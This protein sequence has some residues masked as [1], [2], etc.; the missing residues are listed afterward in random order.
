MS[1]PAEPSSLLAPQASR[2]SDHSSR[3][4]G[5]LLSPG[6]AM[7]NVGLTRFIAQPGLSI[8]LM[9]DEP[10]DYEL[11]AKWLTDE[12]V[13][14]FAYG[15]DKPFGVDRV[16]ARFRPRVRGEDE[17]VPCILG[18]NDIPVGYMQYYPV[19]AGREYGIEAVTGVFGVDLFIGEPD[20]WDRGIGAQALGMLV[21]HLFSALGAVRVV[22]DP[23]VTNER[24]IRCYEKSG[25]KKVK[26]LAR[27][28]LH[29]GKLRDAWLMV[30]D[31]PD[32][33]PAQ[34]P[35]IS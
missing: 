30:R 26:V 31:R 14:E 5:V 22:I 21:R 25:F 32:G 10:Q 29:E 2:G 23:L 6:V 28:E 34:R 24:A 18:H 11:M 1:G 3:V 27:H 16:L 33:L 35:E 13:L 20:L 9:R 8:R 4:L 12:R 7:W 19:S 15:R 17:V